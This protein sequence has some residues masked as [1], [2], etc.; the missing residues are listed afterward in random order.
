MLALVALPGRSEAVRYAGERIDVF[1]GQQEGRWIIRTRRLAGQD[2]LRTVV[3]C[4]PGGRCRPFPRRLRI[5]MVPGAGEYDWS[6]PFDLNGVS[7]VLEAYVYDQGF[8]GT[9]D[10]ADQTSFGSISGRAV[11]RNPNPNPYP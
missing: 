11:Q 3:R 5:D 9:Y 2:V 7:C 4:R 8:E 1:T 10:C 6:G